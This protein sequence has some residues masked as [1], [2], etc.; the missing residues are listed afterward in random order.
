MAKCFWVVINTSNNSRTVE[1][2]RAALRGSSRPVLF[3]R[4][5]TALGNCEVNTIKERF[6]VSGEL[7]LAE[8][9]L[10]SLNLTSKKCLV[11]QRLK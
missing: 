4:I 7:G 6:L 10:E 2:E 11:I 5:T 3:G 9:C 8:Y 1:S